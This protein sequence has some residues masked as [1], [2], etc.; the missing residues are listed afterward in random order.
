MYSSIDRDRRVK[1]DSASV[2]IVPTPTQKPQTSDLLTFAKEATAALHKLAQDLAG[3]AGI[4]GYCSSLASELWAVEER[5]SQLEDIVEADINRICRLLYYLEQLSSP[6]STPCHRPKVTIKTFQRRLY[7]NLHALTSHRNHQTYEYIKV[8]ATSKIDRAKKRRSEILKYL[9]AYAPSEPVQRG[10]DLRTLAT[11]TERAISADDYLLYLNSLYSTLGAYCFRREVEDGCRV[12]TILRLKNWKRETGIEESVYFDLLFLG[13]PHHNE[14][15]DENCEW[16]EACICVALSSRRRLVGWEGMPELQQLQPLPSQKS[17]GDTAKL[18]PKRNF[19][20]WVRDMHREQCRAVYVASNGQLTHRETELVSNEF[21]L[22]FASI[23]LATLLDKGFLANSQQKALLSYLLVKAA[24]ELYY[25]DWMTKEW[26]KHSIHFMFQ[27]DGSFPSH[28]AQEA[29]PCAIYVSEPFIEA[30]FES[31]P[32]TE[33]ERSGVPTGSHLYPKILAL[34]IMLLEI[35]LGEHL[36]DKN[37]RDAESI[38]N[39]KHMAAS[40]ILFE[41]EWKNNKRGGFKCIREIIETCILPDK[42]KLGTDPDNL[43]NVLYREIVWPCRKLFSA[44]W[45]ED[46]DTFKIR[47]ELPESVKSKSRRNQT[48]PNSSASPVQNSADDQGQCD[49]T[50]QTSRSVSPA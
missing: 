6:I 32:S 27:T 28:A 24:W 16:H 39:G 50:V 46:P 15:S 18:V 40:R 49:L 37:G 2:P 23:S 17:P 25:S 3:Q 9:N 36:V 22:K 48:T 33:P 30:E 34:G 35:E 4:K 10:P 11:A 31:S 45:D 41:E 21:L 43:R 1:R 20:S 42:A 8:L 44:A 5:L 14:S 13:H 12:N 38:K 7:P 26:S 19:C 47:L 29:Q